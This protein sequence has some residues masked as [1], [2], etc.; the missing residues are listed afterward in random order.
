MANAAERVYDDGQILVEA[1]IGIGD[2]GNNAY[3]LSGPERDAVTVIDAPGGAEA[4]LEAVGTRRIERIVVTHSHFDHWAGFDVLRAATD[5][6]VYAGAEE[7]NLEESQGILPLRHGEHVA[8]GGAPAEV[9]HTPG[10]TPGSICLHFGG[11][12]LTGDT[13]FP[14]GPGRT[15]DHAALL[16]EVESIATRLLVLPPET[17]VLPGHGASCTIAASTAEH[18]VFAGK[19]HASDLAGD[20][21]WLES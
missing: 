16:Q 6:P 12:V 3:I 10:H 17:L 20:V 2:Y 13:L 19:P 14:G 4:I 8:I 7:T 5:A 21:L 11:V 18:A 1:L 15:R 9:I